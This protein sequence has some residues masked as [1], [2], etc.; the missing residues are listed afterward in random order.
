MVKIAKGCCILSARVCLNKGKMEDYKAFKKF[1]I[2]PLSDRQ[3]R[4][5]LEK[6]NPDFERAKQGFLKARNHPH[7]VEGM[8]TIFRRFRNVS[9][10]DKAIAIWAE[11]DLYILKLIP[12]GERINKE[13]A[14]GK[15]SKQKINEIFKEVE[16][17]NSRLT[18]LE[19]DFSYTLGEGT[20]WLEDT[21][22]KTLLFTAF[23]AAKDRPRGRA[24][25]RSARPAP[26]HPETSRRT[27]PPASRTATARNC[28]PRSLDRA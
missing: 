5:E 25:S 21:L 17:I 27:S 7:D 28:D 3:A 15:P 20:R 26:S 8:M 16:P 12:I 22:L 1:L 11:A 10:I 19:E 24:S 23:S 13:Y 18:T 2:V 14:T 9:Y 6:E 4:I